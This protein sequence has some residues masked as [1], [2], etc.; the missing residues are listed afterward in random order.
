MTMNDAALPTD[1]VDNLGL[2]PQPGHNQPPEEDALKL[3]LD[4][5]YKGLPPRLVRLLGSFDRAPAVI[6]TDKENEDASD[7][8]KMFRELR[9]E[10]EAGQEKEAHGF[11]VGHRLV[12]GW[13][14]KIRTPAKDAMTKLTERKT[15]YEREVAA[16]KLLKLQ[17]EERRLREEAEARAAEAERLLRE[18]AKREA[19]A[20]AERERLAREAAEREAMAQ[21]AQE[22]REEEERQA[23][24]EALERANAAKDAAERAA[25]AERNRAEEAERQEKA[26]HERGVREAEERA[27]EEARREAAKIAETQKAIGLEKTEAA[28]KAAKLAAGDVVKAKRLAGGKPADMSRSRSD[29]GAVSSLHAFWDHT[30]VDK[31]CPDPVDRDKIDLEPLRPHLGME[32]LDKAVKSFIKAEGRRLRGV[33]IFESTVSRG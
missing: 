14:G 31:D 25:A 30:P 17:A 10:A 12:L 26:A 1:D 8:K 29:L 13:F 18:A 32:A 9:K 33:R 24:R 16:A 11:I 6:T 5:L 21:A 28:K 2:P 7:L 23:Q 3:K 15:S 4:E 20:Q 19:E 22:A 27:A